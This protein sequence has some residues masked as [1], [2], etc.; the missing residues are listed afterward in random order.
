MAIGLYPLV[1]LKQVRAKLVELSS[2]VANSTDPAMAKNANRKAA[3]E[4][5]KSKRAATADSFKV[6]ADAFLNC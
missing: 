3:R 5:M 2:L 1:M 6:P 4:V